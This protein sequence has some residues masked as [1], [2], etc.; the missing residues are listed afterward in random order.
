MWRLNRIKAENLCAFRELDYSLQQGVTTLIFG[1]NRDNES[2]RSN[3]SGKSALIEAIAIGL[4]GSPLRKIKNEEI[5]NDAADECFVSLE[6]SNT[7][8]SEVFTIERNI[9]RKGASIVKCSDSVQHS[10]DAYNKYIL[11]KIGIS[12][13]ELFN[14]FLLSK[15][16]YSE[17]LSASDK[18]KKEIINRFSNG[19]VVDEAIEKIV[20]DIAPIQENLRSAEL[21]FASLEGRISMLN[22]QIIEEANSRESRI[23][24]KSERIAS[25]K[26]S[27]QE[28]QGV[29]RGLEISLS[30]TSGE[31]SLIGES[32]DKLQGLENSELAI[33]TLFEQV[34]EETSTYGTI[35][36]WMEVMEQSKTKIQTSNDKLTTLKTTHA[37]AQKN[38]NT[39]KKSHSDLQVEYN[40]FVESMGERNTFFENELKLLATKLQTLSAQSEKLRGKRRTITSAIEAL[41]NKLAGTITCPKCSH[42]FLASDEEFDVVEANE[43][44]STQESELATINSEIKTNEEAEATIEQSEQKTTTQRR[45]LTTQQREWLQKLAASDKEVQSARFALENIEREQNQLTQTIASLQAESDGVKRKIFDEAFELIDK[46]YRNNERKEKEL[47]ADLSSAR[48]SVETLRS[49]IE[50]IKSSSAD[51]M[52]EKL[53]AS[54][55]EARK[56]SSESLLKKSN[57]EKELSRLTEQQQRFIEFRSYLANT[58][59]TALSKITNE[60]LESIGSDL[61]INFSGYTKLKSGK[62]REKISVSILRDGIDCGSFGKLSAGEAS[63]IH[64]STILAMQKL[65]NSNCEDD[66]GLDLLVLDEILAAVDEEGHAKMFDSLNS[67][68]LT[69]LIVSHGHVSEAYP[70]TLIIRKEGNESRIV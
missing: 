23:A 40:S 47:K 69:A 59:V 29:I 21:E 16:K 41:K 61:R 38:L 30:E 51:E 22:E 20:A 48:A 58:K 36:D 67:L 37:E 4:T 70:H 14:N 49:T 34:K 55:K 43:E 7:S 54:L 9:Y 2:Q 57:I 44:L 15:H 39:I 52:A 3:G 18:E 28:K 62:I 27:I 10:V 31:K 68:S 1:D 25:I 42:E 24:G 33:E 64:L 26:T 5:I 11:E 65:V 50:E 63:R 6:F 66:K 45:E 32:D 19:I 56:Q 46:M 17:F 53:Q 8:S 12:R 60:F 13:E 35:T